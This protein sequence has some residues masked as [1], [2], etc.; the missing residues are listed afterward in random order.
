MHSALDACFSPDVNITI[1]DSSIKEAVA[2]IPTTGG[3]VILQSARLETV[4]I[5]CTSS[6][7]AHVCR[8]LG[9]EDAASPA[10]AL[11]ELRGLVRR[12][13]VVSSSSVFERDLIFLHLARRLAPHTHRAAISRWQAWFA[14]VDRKAPFPRWTKTALPGWSLTK[15]VSCDEGTALIGPFRDKHKLTRFTDLLDDLFDLCRF[16]HILEQAPNGQACAYKEMGKCPAPC[17]GS[18][19]MAVYK[20]R[21]AQAIAF[22]REPISAHIDRINDTMRRAA[23]EQSFEQAKQ[24]KGQLDALGP[25]SKSEFGGVGEL[26]D[27]RWLALVRCARKGWIRLWLITPSLAA[28]ICDLDPADRGAVAE[29]LVQVRT[30]EGRVRMGPISD[31]AQETIGLVSHHVLLAQSRRTDAFVRLGEH[32][33]TAEELARL[34]RRAAR[35]KETAEPEADKG[36]SAT[37]EPGAGEGHNPAHD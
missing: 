37:F 19:T 7:R 4:L 29:S 35:H 9:L 6:A 31:A 28:P 22:S 30:F 12:I 14:H 10:P 17:D 20:E 11:A 2:R 23:E 15:D 24:L 8:K 1:E 25:F 32:T 21:L 5:A 13:L 33:P 27:F 18:E 26:E 36:G 3:V 16:P 34:M